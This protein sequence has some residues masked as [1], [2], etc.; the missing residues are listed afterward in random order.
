MPILYLSL[1]IWWLKKC[2]Y[3][4][5]FFN[6]RNEKK[7]Q[8]HGND[9]RIINILCMTIIR[10]NINL[11]DDTRQSLVLIESTAEDRISWGNSE[12]GEVGTTKAKLHN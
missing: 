8:G 12:T 9:N 5:N 2:F 4:E 7:E 6:L 1:Q 10:L 11:V 3:R